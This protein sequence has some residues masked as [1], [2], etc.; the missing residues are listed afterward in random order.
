MTVR[1][2]N[3]S[4]PNSP[5]TRCEG[6]PTPYPCNDR[7]L[8]P[9]PIASP[10]T[11]RRASTIGNAT[12]PLC[13]HAATLQDIH[14]TTIVQGNAIATIMPNAD[15]SPSHHLH[16]DV[17]SSVDEGY[18]DDYEHVMVLIAS[19][20]VRSRNGQRDPASAY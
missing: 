8:A 15:H 1:S 20:Q 13:M 2:N 18:I 11:S 5:P 7:P 17:A 14:A 16:V 3:E 4:H 10:S 6:N 19:R 9:Y 12:V